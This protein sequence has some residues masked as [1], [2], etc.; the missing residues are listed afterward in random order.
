[1]T[2]REGSADRG[3]SSSRVTFWKGRAD[4]LYLRVNWWIMYSWQYLLYRYGSYG[5]ME[6]FSRTVWDWTCFSWVWREFYIP[7]SSVLY[8]IYLN[9]KRPFLILSSLLDHFNSETCSSFF[10]SSY[11]IY[12][13]KLISERLHCH[14]ISITHK[15]PCGVF[16][17]NKV[18]TKTWGCL[19]LYVKAGY[20][21]CSCVIV[22]LCCKGKKQHLLLSHWKTKSFCVM[23]YL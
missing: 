22:Y 20:K 3:F 13:N 5:D 23:S 10:L 21:Q 14:F 17:R 7:L 16:L 12:T 15:D 18:Y 2:T 9:C 19:L 6:D 8:S 11:S 4:L 1:M